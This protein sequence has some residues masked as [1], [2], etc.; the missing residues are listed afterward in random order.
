MGTAVEIT[1]YISRTRYEDLPK[2]AV[3]VAKKAVVD[4]VGAGIAGSSAPLGKMVAEMVKDGG[5]KKQSSILVYGDRV[6][7]R[8]A[9]FG[10]AVMARC[11]ELSDVQEG[12]PRRGG[13]HG[14]HTNVVIV[15]AAL[16]MLETSTKPVSGKKLILAIAVGGDLT[17]RLRVAA[18]EAGRQHP[19]ASSTP[20]HGSR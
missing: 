19:E 5:G 10:N 4:T 2:E 7:A 3:E 9:A 17:I 15:P 18:G 12:N 13:S 8:E 6:P 11:R 16:A 1:K 20:G 14:G